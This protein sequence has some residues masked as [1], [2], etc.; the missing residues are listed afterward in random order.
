[1]TFSETTLLVIGSDRVLIA[2]MSTATGWDVGNDEGC[3]VGADVG[4]DEGFEDGSLVDGCTVLGIILG[5]IDGISD[6]CEV[7]GTALGM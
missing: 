4:T 2:M 5:S 6:G 1:L 7:N 3:D